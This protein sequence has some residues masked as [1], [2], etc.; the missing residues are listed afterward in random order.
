M[1]GIC[2]P[3]LKIRKKAKCT[4]YNNTSILKNEARLL[5]VTNVKGKNIIYAVS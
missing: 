1:K 4:K 5:K 3:L 2:H